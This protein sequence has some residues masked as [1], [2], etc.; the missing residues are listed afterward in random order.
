MW[1]QFSVDEERD[2]VFMPTGNPAPDFYGGMRN[3][4]DY[5]G[6]SVIAVRAFTGEV[7]WHFQTVHHDLWDYDVPC[8]PT[9]THVVRDGEEIPVVIQSTKMGLI[10]GA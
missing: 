2:L 9:L 3:G 6:S 8:Q 7:V 4:V 1:A 5:Y 10:L